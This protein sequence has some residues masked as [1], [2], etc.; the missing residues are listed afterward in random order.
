LT[1]Q[2]PVTFTPAQEGIVGVHYMLHYY[3]APG[4][5]LKLNLCQFSKFASNLLKP[6]KVIKISWRRYQ[7]SRKL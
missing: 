1:I 6:P 7:V 5:F 3:I 4:F 2:Y